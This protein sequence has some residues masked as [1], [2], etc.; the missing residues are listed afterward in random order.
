M[1]VRRRLAAAGTAFALVPVA[2][3]CSS[4]DP[5]PVQHTTASS[6]LAPTRW[7]A[8]SASES[9]S[10]I[11]PNDPKAAARQLH[12]SKSDYC[13]MLKQTVAAGK[14]ILPGVTANDPALMASTK[15]FLAEIEAVAPDPVAGPWTVLGGAVLA[16]VG[17]R[18]DAAK[19]KGIDAAA[20]REAVRTV[21]ADAKR[22][23]GV[24]LSSVA[25]R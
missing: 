20:V 23:C 17:S 13:A 12:G 6:N 9:G 3:A 4:S 24:D 21:A 11:D 16:L 19:V 18:G 7:W 15:A 10:P 25:S 8:N 14:S 1:T 2:A 22:S 5:G